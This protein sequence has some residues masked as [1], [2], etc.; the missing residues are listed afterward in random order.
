[1]TRMRWRVVVLGWITYASF[2]FGRVNIASALPTIESEFGWTPEQTGVLV[3]ASLVTYA[4][5]QLINGWLGERFD[6]RKLVFTGLVGSSIINLVF[7]LVAEPNALLILIGLWLVNGLFQSMGWGPILRTLSDNLST[8]QRRRISGVFGSCYV[9]GSTLTWALTALLLSVGQWRLAF[10]VP[11]GLMVGMGV[12]WYRLSAHIATGRQ[13]SHVLHLAAV[14]P[15]VSQ[16]LPVVLTSLIAGALING[17]LLFAPSF[18]AEYLPIDQAALVAA[19]FPI[20]GLIG[21]IW[22]GGS[23]MKRFADP[24]S[25]LT[26]LLVLSALARALQFVLPPSALTSMVLLA[27]MGITSYALTNIL[28]TA[29]PLL[30]YAHLGTSMVAGVIDATH[31]VGGAVGSALV[32]LLL[33]RGGWNLVFVVWTL[34]PLVAIGFVATVRYRQFA[35][36]PRL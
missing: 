32:G 15:M 12:I 29:V 33:T 25:S 2:Y 13:S 7:A 18:V 34:L 30:S 6:A 8:E 3:G 24:L 21:T 36:L 27:A 4:A 28:L 23:V 10:I 5:G 14:L 31:S 19:V 26:V 9:I 22:L 35:Q 17:A 16:I 11:A 1:M 20:C